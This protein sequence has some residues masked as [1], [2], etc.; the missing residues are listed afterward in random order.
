MVDW[1]HDDWEEYLERMKWQ[2]WRPK[3]A[4]EFDW[5]EDQNLI[6]YRS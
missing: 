1:D 5:K 3:R 2:P 4:Q 6:P